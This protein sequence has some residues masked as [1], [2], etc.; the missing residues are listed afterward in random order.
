MIK[1]NSDAVAIAVWSDGVTDILNRSVGEMLTQREV[2]LAG[3]EEAKAISGSKA[4]SNNAWIETTSSI[5]VMKIYCWIER[6]RAQREQGQQQGA[7]QAAG[8]KAD[9]GS[10]CRDIERK[11]GREVLKIY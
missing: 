10:G 8:S 1:L 5:E 7:K 3:V 6:K 4:G 9:R 11:F 2:L